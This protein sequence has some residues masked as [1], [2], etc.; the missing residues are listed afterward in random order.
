[1]KTNLLILAVCLILLMWGC[2]NTPSNKGGSKPV[3]DQSHV[4]DM[5]F[6]KEGVTTI[7]AKRKDDKDLLKSKKLFDSVSFVRLSNLPEATLGNINQIIMKDSLLIIRDC[8]LSRSI[9]L[10]SL[11]GEFLGTV[12]RHGRG[13]GEYI[14]PTFMQAND[15]NIIVWDQFTQH[16]LF[17]D[18]MGKYERTLQFPFFAM[19]FYY[20][21]D[22][23]IYFNT[24]NSDNDRLKEIVNYT[25]FETDSSFKITD[26]GFYRKK[27]TYE[28]LLY[29][30]NFFE[31][32][33][34]LYY[35][36]VYC[37][38]LYSVDNQQ[39]HI[40]AEYALDFGNK[41]VPEKL[42]RG[43]RRKEL[44][45][46][47]AR[48]RYLFLGG[49]IF[50]TDRHLNYSYTEAH[51]VKDCIYSI[52][53]QRNYVVRDRAEFFPLIFLNIVGSTDDAF[54]GFFFPGLI[55]NQL[56]GWK[57]IPMKDRLA[58]FG[59][60]RTELGMSIKP[61]DNPI[62]TFFYPSTDL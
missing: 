46:E 26:R 37:D 45:E 30:H 38:T 23:H 34:I 2:G 21:N 22:D 5:L 19:K 36:P 48:S 24:I 58:Q 9:K 14:E 41:T 35:L 47:Q 29:D 57:E 7:D 52:R 44:R 25:L 15:R 10:F 54:I 20:V 43:K 33:G 16:L 32:K 13:P 55:S 11:S 59:K 39:N 18:L 6:S 56:E 3:V 50:L 49:N 42:R 51:K 40:K 12:G 27:N 31:Q 8:Y 60:G 4:K 1:M 17:Y 28:N 53:T 62:I 61:D